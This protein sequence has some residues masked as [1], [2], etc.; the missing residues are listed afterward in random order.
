MRKD[1]SAPHEV[2]LPGSDAWVPAA[3][4]PEIAAAWLRDPVSGPGAVPM[5]AAPEKAAAE[6]I[7][8]HG[9]FQVGAHTRGGVNPGLKDDDSEAALQPVE[10]RE[11]PRFR[12]A[13]QRRLDYAESL[14]TAEGQEALC[15]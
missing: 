15:W 2:R 7:P 14:S 11:S 12:S 1:Q 4:V 8:E 3:H 9:P 5:P 10:G 13:P 6:A